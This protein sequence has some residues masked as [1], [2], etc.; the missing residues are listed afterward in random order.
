[1][2]ISD[3][4]KNQIFF[5][6]PAYN[7]GNMI[8][9]VLKKLDKEGFKNL[10]IVD[11]GSSDNTFNSVEKYKL[12]N[13]L[14]D[15][16]LLK[17]IINR[18]QGAALLTGME[19]AR[20]IKKCKYIVHFDSDGQHR[21]SDLP[22]FIK[23]LENEMVDIVMGSRFLNS[24]TRKLV[25]KK[26]QILLKLGILI[27]R[28]LSRIKLTDT[29]NGYRVLTKDAAGKIDITLDGF[30]HA[31]EILDEVI[32]NKLKYKEVPVFID[33]TDYSKAKGQKISNS[34]KIFL[35]MVFKN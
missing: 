29:H 4:L 35:K 34:V 33:Y 31:S 1:M 30:E 18:G 5:V 9:N 6:I 17:H 28:F 14:D 25:P 27:T 23:V 12:K 13:S 19:Y 11:D 20:N 8:L 24:E 22:K 21:I 32:K 3:E 7:E 10:V 15:L 26:K 2:K 16:V